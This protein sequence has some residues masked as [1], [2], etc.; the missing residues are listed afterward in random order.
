MTKKR[1][2]GVP[3]ALAA[4]ASKALNP[5]LTALLRAPPAES[6]ALRRAAELRRLN[7]WEVRGAS[8]CS[9]VGTCL[10][11]NELRRIAKKCRFIEDP[12]ALTD[13]D[14]HGLI[15]SR[16]NND[17]P[18]S[19]AVTKHLDAKFEGA[20]RKCRGLDDEEA[21]LRYWESAV[22][23]GLVPGAYWALV[24]HPNLPM[25]VEARVYGEIHMMSHMCGASNRGDARAIA[26]ARRE[27]GEIARRLAARLAER[28]ERLNA[29]RDQL[30]ALRA[31]L[32]A[33]EPL[34]AECLRLRETLSRNDLAQELAARMSE[35]GAVN[36]E[37]AELGKSLAK[38]ELRLESLRARLDE[39]ER[40]AAAQ[41]ASFGQ[42]DDREPAAEGSEPP[43]DNLCGRCLLYVGGRPQTVCQLRALVMGLNGRLLHHDGGIEQS[44][45]RLGELVRQAD[46]VFFPVNCVSHGAMDYVKK[47]CE[48]H[49]K[50]MV[51]LRTAGVTA[52]MR[53]IGASDGGQATL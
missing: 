41:A 50:P 37:K 39:S 17:N 2:F 35:I 19:R 42:Y 12:Y 10:T 24:T 15:T 3:A 49:G 46:Q 14:I 52:F 32:R 8:L 16:M 4:A 44:S 9:I 22:E 40:R 28:D 33:Q 43:C 30:G 11:L 21:F 27:K 1:D 51:P 26:E 23:A 7:I 13:Y 47:L 53:A 20:L 29:L 18:V 25:S 5:P 45:A 48:S 31:K 36:R 38:A 34:V 6:Y